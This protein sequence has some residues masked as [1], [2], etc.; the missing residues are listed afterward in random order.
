[1][2]AQGFPLCKA[3]E[4]LELTIYWLSVAEAAAARVLTIDEESITAF[5]DFGI[6]NLHETILEAISS[7][8]APP[9]GQSKPST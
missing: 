7:G 4:I 3:S 9:K 2:R 8:G 6:D 5:G 1:M